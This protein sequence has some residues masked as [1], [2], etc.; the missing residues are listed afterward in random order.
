M[1]LI[2]EQ[3]DGLTVHMDD[4]PLDPVREKYQTEEYLKI[5]GKEL[6]ASRSE[7]KKFND[8]ATTTIE[9]YCNKAADATQVNAPKSRYNL[10]FANTDIKHAALYQRVPEPS[11]KRRFSDANDDSSRVASMLLQR[12]IVIDL[13]TNNFDAKFKE[14]LF[15]RLVPGFGVMW[16]RF[17]EEELSPETVEEISVV[18]PAT[19]IE[20]IQQN[21][22][23]AVKDQNAIV[24]YVSWDDFLWSPCRV[25]DECR[26][27]AR[28]VPMTNDQLKERFGSTVAKEVLAEIQY[29]TSPDD[30]AD[31]SVSRLYTQNQTAETADVFEI[32]DKDRKLIWFICEHA[33]LPLDVVEDT[34]KF[35]G[36][37]PSPVPPLGR[38][39]TNSTIPISDYSEVSD[40]YVRLDRLSERVD[41]LVKCVANRWVYDAEVTELADLFTKPENHGVPV[42]NFGRFMEKGGMAGAIQFT[43]LDPY[44]NAL[45]VIQQ[46]IGVT[47]Q[48][49][50]EIEGLADFMR[51][52]TQ[53][54]DTA[55]AIRQK[56][57]FAP[58]RLGSELKSIAN[59]IEKLYSLVVHIISKYYDDETIIDHAGAMPEADQQYFG[60]ALKLIRADFQRNFH[61]KVSVDSLQDPRWQSERADRV[62]A[63][64]AVSQMFM[65]FGPIMQSR[66]ELVPLCIEMIKFSFA[67]MRGAENI[68]GVLDAH[69]Q[70]LQAQSQNAQQQPKEPSKE[71]I[72]AQAQ[73][74]H[75]QIELQ[76]A[77]EKNQTDL[78]IEQ[79]RA[80]SR[81]INDQQELQVANIHAGIKAAEVQAKI[82]S[83]A[84]RG[85]K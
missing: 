17:E 25:W 35:P 5:W 72:K 30:S 45:A 28:R 57:A 65:Q 83:D 2:E 41:Q 3:E 8:T 39:S 70:A 71:E 29:T 26:W 1:D 37:F 27:E 69:L 33:A 50:Y 49:I 9:R 46:Q 79:Q 42:N 47:I 43:P 22:T 44:T 67:G 19:G 36:F 54:Y 80:Q 38:F 61:L 7:R 56:G 34:T 10:F 31:K 66:P 18:D 52:E 81:A 13:D 60:A 48:Q 23:P 24:D 40:L 4:T 21:V 20:S 15:N 53:A 76:K 68:E 84:T 77:R 74:Q 73:V 14:T 63:I 6:D 32:W 78:L 12:N 62:A 16:V 82:I 51:G 64:G 11:I 59:Y 58:S 85:N 55:E 75:D